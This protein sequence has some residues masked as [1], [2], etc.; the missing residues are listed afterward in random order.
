MPA[1]AWR[2]IVRDCG[3]GLWLWP[4]WG[5]VQGVRLYQWLISPW[6][7]NNCRFVPSCSQYFIES[8]QQRGALVGSWRGIRRICRCHPWHPGGWD[9][10]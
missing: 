9:P 10:P 6:L 7:G 1:T 4:R 2:E 8:V 3:R 5:L